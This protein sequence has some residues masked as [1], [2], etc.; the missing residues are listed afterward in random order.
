MRFTAYGFGVATAAGQPMPEVFVHYVDPRR[1]VRRTISLGR[2]S[3][4]CGTIRRTALRR[5]FPFTPRSGTWALQFD[6]QRTYHRGTDNSRFL[7]D[8]PTLTVSAA[9]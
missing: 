6:T 7:F 1:K 4:P 5:L 2:G 3:A 9:G 8:R